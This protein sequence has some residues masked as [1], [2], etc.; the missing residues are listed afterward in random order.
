[1]KKSNRSLE[2]SFKGKKDDFKKLYRQV[3]SD[4]SDMTNIQKRGVIEHL[5]KLA[6]NSEEVWKVVKFAEKVSYYMTDRQKSK[7]ISKLVRFSSG[8]EMRDVENYAKE[9]R[10]S[11]HYVMES[12]EKEIAGIFT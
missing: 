8:S 1:M 7:I 4:C 10:L 6:K 9:N 11:L 5:I 2:L 3:K 12:T